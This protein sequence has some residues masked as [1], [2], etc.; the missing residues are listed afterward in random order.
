MISLQEYNISLKI[1]DL[2]EKKYNI[3]VPD[4]EVIYLTLL[5]SSIQEEQ[6]NERVAIIV[7]LHGSSGASSMVNVAKR[8]LGEG[9]L[10]SIDMP[11]DVSPQRVLKDIIEKVNEIDMGRGVLLLVD[12]GSLT[13]FDGII[14]E[15]T[16]IRVKTIDMASTPLVLEAVRKANLLDMDLDTLYDSLKD[17]KGYGLYSKDAKKTSRKKEVRL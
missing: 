4:M 16:G 5:I 11:L 2:I 14:T 8:L 10:E 12:M 1:K 7:A 6:N 17:F 9:V 3:I 13:S 15:K